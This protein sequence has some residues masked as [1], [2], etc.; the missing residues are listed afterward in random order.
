MLWITY[1]ALHK[2]TTAKA[3]H[4]NI[5]LTVK[6]NCVRTVTMHESVAA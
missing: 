4:L 1:F 2:Y 6:T 5:T 3:K